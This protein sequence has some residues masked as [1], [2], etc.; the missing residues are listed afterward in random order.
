LVS[1]AYLNIASVFNIHC[2]SKQ[3]WTSVV[4]NFVDLSIY[5]VSTK[6]RPPL[7]IF[8]NLQN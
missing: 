6:K 3:Q 1:V 4:R 2:D 8:K 7:G 5:T